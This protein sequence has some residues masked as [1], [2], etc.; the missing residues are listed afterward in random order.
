MQP[1]VP[2]PQPRAPA[3]LFGPIQPLVQQPRAQASLFGPIQPQIV[4]MS[5][6]APIQSQTSQLC[7]TQTV[8]FVPVQAQTFQSVNPFLPTQPQ[9]D[10]T[11]VL[12]VAQSIYDHPY[13]PPPDLSHILGG[14]EKIAPP[15][16]TTLIGDNY[17][18]PPRVARVKPRHLIESPDPIDDCGSIRHLVIKPHVTPTD[19]VTPTE[20]YPK[21]DSVEYHTNPPIGELRQMD[22]SQVRNFSI[23]RE[24]YGRIDFCCNVD[25]RGIDLDQLV[26]I[27]EGHVIVYPYTPS[28]TP[29]TG[30]N[31]PAIVTLFKCFPKKKSIV[32]ITKTMGAE[33]ISYN[34]H[35]GTWV[36]KVSHF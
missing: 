4:P 31:Q 18:Y 11:N 6:S 3:P 13:G 32:T 10:L 2:Q 36:F 35:D 5:I 30:L 15:P 27:N 14:L 28:P 22:V 17:M 29:G 26:Q 20:V 25:L 34:Q 21:L 16:T 23:V 1:P 12:A 24:G 9:T 33:L 8:P 19:V 7:S